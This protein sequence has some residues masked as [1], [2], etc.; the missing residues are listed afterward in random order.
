MNN[1]YTSVSVP[2]STPTIV[3]SLTVPERGGY[4]FKG[5]I[6]WSDVDCEIEIKFNLNTIGGGRING[7]T[8]TLTLDYASSPYG[9][10]AGDSLIIIAYHEGS[11][12]HDVKSTMLM[13]QL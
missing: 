10:L 12:A 5:A 13:E 11:V 7:A 2:P 3:N 9:L 8:Q 1:Q 4:S 6:I